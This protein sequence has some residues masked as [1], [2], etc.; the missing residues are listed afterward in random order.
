M[1]SSEVETESNANQMHIRIRI[2]VTRRRVNTK[3]AVS[4]SA[5]EIRCVFD[6][7]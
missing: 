5:E 6:N 3:N 2:N 1:I 7:I 4:I